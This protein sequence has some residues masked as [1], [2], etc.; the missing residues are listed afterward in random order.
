MDI[1]A[2]LAQHQDQLMALPG[3]T[4]VGIGQQADRPVIVVMV[5]ELT[6]SVREAVPRTLDGHPVVVE[7]TGEITAFGDGAS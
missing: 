2:V 7:G 3:V 5:R 6:P 4:G 1:D